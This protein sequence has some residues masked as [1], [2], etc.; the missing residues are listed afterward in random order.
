MPVTHV[1]VETLLV[2]VFNEERGMIWAKFYFLYS[3]LANA[4]LMATAR[5]HKL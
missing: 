4:V 3:S 2:L 1:V 5:L